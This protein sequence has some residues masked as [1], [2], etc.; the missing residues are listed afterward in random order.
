[1]IELAAHK[2]TDTLESLLLRV[3]EPSQ[4]AAE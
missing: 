3:S 4:L 1:M 2:P